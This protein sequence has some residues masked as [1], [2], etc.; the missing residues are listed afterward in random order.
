MAGRR[1]RWAGP[2]DGRSD[3]LAFGPEQPAWSPDGKT[4]AF[5]LRRGVYSV[6]A[7]GG[8]LRILVAGGPAQTNFAHAPSYAAD[9]RH[10]AYVRHFDDDPAQL[11]WQLVVRDLKD[12]RERV[13]A[14]GDRGIEHG[15]QSSSPDST[16]LAFGENRTI[17]T[18]TPITHEGTVSIVRSDGTGRR[19][20]LQRQFVGAPAWG[21]ESAQLLRQAHR[22]R[23]GDRGRPRGANE[24]VDPLDP[25]PTSSSGSCHR[26]DGSAIPLVAGKWTLVRIYVGDA[27]L[28]SGE[29]AER[30]LRFTISGAGL[31]APME[32]LD[33][34]KVTAPDR[35]RPTDERA[36][37]N[38]WLPDS[39]VRSSIRSASRWR[40]TPRKRRTECSDC[41]PNGNRA[42]LNGICSRTAA[43]CRWVRCRSTSSRRQQRHR[44]AERLR[45]PVARHG[46][47]ASGRGLRNRRRPLTRARWSRREVHRPAA[48]PVHQRRPEER[49]IHAP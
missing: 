4:I 5:A 44:P 25:N 38:V 8:P 42:S 20:L 23:A 36:A 6:P 49:G 39:A 19:P 31:T 22:G 17:G 48:R 26:S 43:A 41:Y 33:T 10:F 46:S 40:S 15:P 47:D 7:A 24:P 3:R 29:G 1:G 27:G 16:K 14:S 34:V 21:S 30:E 35:L 11:P 37:L 2:F 18:S 13:L 28:A 12:G 32:R 45:D 9:G